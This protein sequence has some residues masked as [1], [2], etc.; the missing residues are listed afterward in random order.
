MTSACK[1][2]ERAFR[3]PLS[4]EQKS[5]YLDRQFKAVNSPEAAARRV[6]LLVLKSPRFL[7]HEPKG[8][9]DP[10]DVAC[11]IS[12]GLWDSLP[13]QTCWRPRPPASWPRGT[14]SPRRP[15]AWSPTCGPEPRSASSCSSG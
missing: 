9:L 11:R 4:D 10:Y 3:R 8:K 6:I 14:R 15:S 7:Y 13:D 2:A 1:F 12:Y 5:F